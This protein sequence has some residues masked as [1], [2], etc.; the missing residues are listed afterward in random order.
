R[1]STE[2]ASACSSVHVRDQALEI[3][4]DEFGVPIPRLTVSERELRPLDNRMDVVGGEK[5]GPSQIEGFEQAQLLEE[6]GPLAPGP[7][8]GHGPA[9]KVDRNRLFVIRFE[10][11]QV[12]AREK[13]LMGGT[14]AV[15]QL[16]SAL[17]VDG[18]RDQGGVERVQ[19]SFDLLPAPSAGR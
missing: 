11:S 3:H 6:H 13:T 10:A 15:H 9:G 5:T 12:R 4:D 18:I 16:V 2:N 17:A 19:C 1:S 14:G 7:A 8:F